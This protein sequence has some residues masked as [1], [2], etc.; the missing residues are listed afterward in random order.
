VRIIGSELPLWFAVAWK[1]AY[2]LVGFVS[3]SALV[4]P[5]QFRSRLQYIVRLMR[6]EAA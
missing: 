5:L 1:I 2:A 4:Q 3:F 6:K